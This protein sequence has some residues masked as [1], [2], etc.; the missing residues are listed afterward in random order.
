MSNKTVLTVIKRELKEKMMSKSFILM[1]LLM[2]LLMFGMI[3]LQ[4][5][6]F[7]V[8]STAVIEIISPYEDFTEDLKKEFEADSHDYELTFTT[9][10]EEKFSEYLES[11]KDSILNKDLTGI[12][13]IPETAF[14]D[15]KV[16]YYSKSSKNM[17][18]ALSLGN[19]INKVLINK[20]FI[21]SGFSEEDID[22]SRNDV[23][24]KD[25]KIAREDEIKEQGYGNLIVA[26]I[27]TFLLYMSLLMMGSSTMTSVLEEKNNRIVEMILSSISAKEFMMG[28]ILGASLTGLAQMTIWLSPIFIVASSAVLFIPPEFIIDLPMIYFL[29]FLINFFIGL[30][31]FIGLFATVGS[32]FE[33]AQDAQSGIWPVMLM[34][35][36]PFFIGIS[37]I[38]NPTSP[39]GIITSFLPLFSII[40]MPVRISI[41]DVHLLEVLMAFLL[42]LG[43]LFLIFPIA[44]KIYQIGILR[45]GKKP[46]FTDL[47]KWLKMN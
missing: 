46:T 19:T 33:T 9:V 35:M 22:Y 18:M 43:A 17:S 12:L 37:M 11:R 27:F 25:Y 10:G 1:T 15:K 45:T 29:Y 6:L 8:E 39:I 42:N 36:I 30:L 5:V 4:T 20:Y 3:G 44:G 40:I 41:G 28:K 23:D 38:N 21:N 32:I 31:L 13:F 16:E 47:K 26:Y 24:F 14:K 2:P 7:Q 34:I